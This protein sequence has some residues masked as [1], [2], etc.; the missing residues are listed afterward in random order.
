MKKYCVKTSYNVDHEI[1]AFSYSV[2]SG[3]LTFYDAH[4]APGMV[5]RDWKF[6]TIESVEEKAE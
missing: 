4:G 5:I 3:I 2:V 6:F 1:E